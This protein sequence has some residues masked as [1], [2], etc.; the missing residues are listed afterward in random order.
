MISESKFKH[1]KQY[2]KDTYN[3][4]TKGKLSNRQS[5]TLIHWLT[6]ALIDST[7]CVE[8]AK[9]AWKEVNTAVNIIVA[10]PAA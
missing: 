2:A 7:D 6:R 8:L 5:T 9:T 10:R 3:A 4:M 1:V